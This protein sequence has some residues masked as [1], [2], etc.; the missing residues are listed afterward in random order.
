MFGEILQ[1]EANDDVVEKFPVV[2]TEVVEISNRYSS[3]SG[4]HWV[5]EHPTQQKAN[6]ITPTMRIKPTKDVSGNTDNAKQESSQK[7]SE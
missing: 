3:E 7:L 1:V 5:R 2:K 4:Q 6:A